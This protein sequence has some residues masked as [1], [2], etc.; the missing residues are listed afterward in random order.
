MARIIGKGLSFDDVLITPK[1]NEVKSRKDVVFKTK[2][3]KNHFIEIPLLA[4]NMDTVCESEMAIIVGR[5]GGLGVIH[6]F[7]SIEEQSREVK[8]VKA[9]NLLSS[10][11][12]GIKDY[13][14]RSRALASA[15]VDIFVL[16][17]AHG[18]SKRVG[19]VL[20]YI[21]KKYPKIDV[22]VGN[23]ATKEAADYFIDKNADAIKVGIGPGSMCTTRIMT[24]VGVPQL[25]AI[26]DIYA[27]SKDRVPICA[28]G[29]IKTSG[30][31][32]KAIGAGADT[33]MLG[34]LFSGT[35][36][37][38]GDVIEENG[39]KYKEYRGMASYSAA[40]KKI[41][42]DGGSKN[43]FVY[44]EGEVV[45]V[46]YKDSVGPIIKKLLGGLASGMTYVGADNIDKIKGKVDF[47]SMTGSGMKESMAHG[48]IR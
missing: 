2:V 28:D 21:K 36:E 24:G 11:A 4:A 42:I 45:K 5:L 31:I 38:P 41:E 39:R 43:D 8:K 9:E 25:T 20:D 34:S 48:L 3:T 40:V 16:D 37:S 30:D 32:T 10:A 12:I 1:Y 44:V 26:M 46:G 35:K 14:E 22:I 17:V 19:A 15:G 27:T 29:G 13:E 7:L 6:R 47:I 18:H 33:V 23:V